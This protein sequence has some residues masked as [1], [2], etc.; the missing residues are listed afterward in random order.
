MFGVTMPPVLLYSE[1]D[2]DAL[3]LKV[4]QTRAVITGVQL[5]IIAAFNNSSATE[6]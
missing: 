2:M 3:A 1:N 6:P 4:L 5:K